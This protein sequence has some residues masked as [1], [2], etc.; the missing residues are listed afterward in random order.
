MGN[1][2][3]MG[4]TKIANPL[5]Y[6]K[7]AKFYQFNLHQNKRAKNYALIKTFTDLPSTRA[8]ERM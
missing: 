2:G 5:N 7:R 8:C 1:M 4:N 6:I 3:N